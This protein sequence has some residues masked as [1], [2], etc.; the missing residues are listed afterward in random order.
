M[1]KEKSVEAL[2]PLKTEL[3]ELDEQI[4]E[5]KLLISSSKAN[6]TRNEDKLQQLLKLM[7]S[8]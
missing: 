2:H 7:S 1:E 4:T 8:A 3:L 5:K 6:I